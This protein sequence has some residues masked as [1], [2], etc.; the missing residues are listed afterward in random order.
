MKRFAQ[1]ILAALL[2][3]PGVQAAELGRLFY[4]PMQRAELDR[5]RLLKTDD[6]DEKTAPAADLV[7]NGRISSSAGR[8]TT[9]VN[10]VPSY[11]GRVP[12]PNA[13]VGQRID[14]NT[15]EIKDPLEGG[16]LVITPSR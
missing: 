9:W 4:T 5:K 12:A 10:G 1:C 6:K 14:S 3:S 2:L 7:I 8:S 13:K 11:D 16:K 15:G